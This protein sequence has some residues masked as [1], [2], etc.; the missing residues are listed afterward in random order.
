MSTFKGHGLDKTD[1][2]ILLELDR[3][4]RQSNAQI[5][6]KL[7]L[8]KNVVNYRITKLLGQEFITRF[9]AVVDGPKIGFQ[10]F[11]AYL[12]FSPLE[13]EKQLELIAFISAQKQTWFAGPIDGDLDFGFL[14]L[15]KNI[16]EFRDFWF[17]FLSRFQGHIQQA[18]VSIYTKLFT[19]QHA[20]LSPQLHGDIPMQVI[21]G[22]FDNVQISPTDKRVLSYLST[23][24]RDSV[25]EIAQKLGLTPSIVRYSMD[26]L[27]ETGVVLAYRTRINFNK[28]GYAMYKLNIRLKDRSRYNALLQYAHASPNIIYT[29]EAIGYADFEVEMLVQKYDEFKAIRQD[30]LDLAGKTLHSHNHFIYVGEILLNYYPLE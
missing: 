10:T 14:F 17:E 3:N 11:R 26:K 1:C 28:L 22:Q 18:V 4:C 25:V 5:G 6:K 7:R 9:Y 13:K 30:L 16:Y 19:Y 12:K 23:N 29:D 2:K 27:E 21:G 8:S 24:A 15:A 20:Y